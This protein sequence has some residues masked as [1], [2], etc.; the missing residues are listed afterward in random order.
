MIRNVMISRHKAPSMLRKLWKRSERAWNPM[1]SSTNKRWGD[2]MSGSIADEHNS[3][4]YEASAATMPTLLFHSAYGA[5]SLLSP[6]TICSTPY[7]HASHTL[8]CS[9]KPRFGLAIGLFPFTKICASEK[10]T[11]HA[12]I[13]TDFLA[14]L[15]AAHTF[16]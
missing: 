7:S 8:S 9:Q 10:P 6:S 2:V 11:P 14:S 3:M 4:R 15:L 5:L 12:R 13:T 1:T 16:A